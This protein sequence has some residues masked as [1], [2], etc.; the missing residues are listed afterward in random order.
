MATV[1]RAL[2][3]IA[4]LYPSKEEYAHSAQVLLPMNAY[5]MVPFK[6]GI[7][8]NEWYP[9]YAAHSDC[10]VL[11]VSPTSGEPNTR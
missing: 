5:F 7:R 6:F 9:Q 2:G 11:N 1:L 4:E 8:K 3:S 10:P